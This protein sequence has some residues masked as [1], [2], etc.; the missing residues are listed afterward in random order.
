MYQRDP[1]REA[2]G[3]SNSLSGV[4]M[5]RGPIRYDAGS[6]HNRWRGDNDR[7]GMRISEIACNKPCTSMIFSVA[8]SDFA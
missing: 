5:L 2:S 4:N 3:H 7:A 8:R 6:I 1:Y